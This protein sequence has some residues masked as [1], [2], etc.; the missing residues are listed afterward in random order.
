MDFNEVFSLNIGG[1]TVNIGTINYKK[2]SDIQANDKIR[3]EADPVPFEFTI[4]GSKEGIYLVFN[5]LNLS[6]C[7]F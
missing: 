7:L 1:N 2:A 6:W 5:S 4:K 3:Y